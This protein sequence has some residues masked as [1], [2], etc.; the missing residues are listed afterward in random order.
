MKGKSS[1]S[2]SVG[3]GPIGPG[4]DTILTIGRAGLDDG[5]DMTG[6]GEGRGA[7]L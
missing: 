5:V 1:Y 3:S 7:D 4:D 2:S 6:D